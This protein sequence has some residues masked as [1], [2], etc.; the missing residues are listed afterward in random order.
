MGKP[1]EPATTDSKSSSL[2]YCI[3]PTDQY[4]E[5]FSLAPPVEAKE[6]FACFDEDN[7]GQVTDDNS[8]WVHIKELIY[9]GNKTDVE[10][11]EDKWVYVIY[12]N[13]VVIEAEASKGLWDVR[14]LKK[15]R[16]I[17][18][19]KGK[20]KLNPGSKGN[21]NAYQF[22]LSPVQMTKSALKEL[23]GKKNVNSM[24]K[25]D[26]SLIGKVVAVPDLF[27]CHWRPP[28]DLFEPP[29]AGTSLQT[30]TIHVHGPCI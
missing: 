3:Y 7:K 4:E 17:A 22:F 25:T 11:I 12:Q 19:K 8:F 30:Q 28:L 23:V 6:I 1:I 29:I 26:C 9:P 2:S 21:R 15:K 24:V 5:I 14:Y 10:E 13:E 16:S 27:P 20:I 18:A